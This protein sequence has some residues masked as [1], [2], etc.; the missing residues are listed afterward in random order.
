MELLKEKEVIKS[1]GDLYSL[2]DYDPLERQIEDFLTKA[3]NT[4]Y[5]VY[6]ERVAN[7]VG[8]TWPTIEE[9]T[10]KVAK[11]LGLTVS[12][13]SEI[14]YRLDNSQNSQ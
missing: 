12:T 14:I 4:L 11:R 9:L 3:L 2:I 7:E 1:D 10:R 13:K 8:K 5:K 6:F